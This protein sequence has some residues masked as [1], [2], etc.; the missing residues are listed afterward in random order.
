MYSYWNTRQFCKPGISS[1]KKNL[2]ELPLLRSTAPR[3]NKLCKNNLYFH[4]VNIIDHPWEEISCFTSKTAG[5][6]GVSYGVADKKVSLLH[7][8]LFRLRKNRQNWWFMAS[9][10]S[11]CILNSVRIVLFLSTNRVHP[12][13]F[14]KSQNGYYVVLSIS[15]HLQLLAALLC[16]PNSLLSLVR[17]RKRKTKKRKREE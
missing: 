5:C 13:V 12:L 16:L 11:V 2:R 4:I 17:V 3:E 8:F 6:C 14:R 10:F 7:S 15:R 9:V 1:S